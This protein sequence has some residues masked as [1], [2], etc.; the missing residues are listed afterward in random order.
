MGERKTS[1]REGD[2]FAIPLRDRGYARGVVARMN[3]V[4]GIL[5]YFFGPRLDSLPNDLS[6][7]ELTASRAVY[8]SICSDMG[9][10]DRTWPVLGRIEPWDRTAWPLPLFGSV[11]VD[12][13]IAWC[14]EYADDLDTMVRH[15]EIPVEEAQRLP[16]D[17]SDGSGAVEIILT[18]LLSSF[19]Q[20]IL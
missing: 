1:Y 8:V 5:G 11:A 12:G 17:G 20:S 6:S 10:Q 18:R 13:S 15:T 3:G 7:G 9:L 16:R 2:W 19:E 14:T 4:G